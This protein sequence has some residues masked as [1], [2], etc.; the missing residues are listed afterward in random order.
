MARCRPGAER[1]PHQRAASAGASSSTPTSSPPRA[2]SS[3]ARARDS[4]PLS[5]L[6]RHRQQGAGRGGQGEPLGRAE[7][8]GPG[9]GGA[10]PGGH[11]GLGDHDL[12]ELVGRVG[13]DAAAGGHLQLGDQGLGGGRSGRPPSS[14]GASPTWASQARMASRRRSR[15]PVSTTDGH[16]ALPAVGPPLATSRSTIARRTAA[17]R[18]DLGVVQQLEDPEDQRLDWSVT[19]SRTTT[20]PSSRRSTTAWPRPARRPPGPTPPRR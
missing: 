18:Q 2:R 8:A 15:A 6:P 13:R 9:Q 20:A 3:L 19:V 10:H 16:S 7:P 11:R 12:H 14:I 5:S 4:A 1:V 17:G